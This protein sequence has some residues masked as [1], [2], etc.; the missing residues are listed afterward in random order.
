MPWLCSFQAMLRRSRWFWAK[1]HICKHDEQ[2]LCENL[3]AGLRSEESDE[4]KKISPDGTGTLRLHLDKDRPCHCP[5]L[6]NIQKVHLVCQTFVVLVRT[7]KDKCFSKSLDPHALA[8][9][10]FMSANRL[11]YNNSC[12]VYTRLK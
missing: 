5:F 12:I 7:T 8:T 9:N 6:H 10:R 1:P 11:T 4:F 3:I 2:R